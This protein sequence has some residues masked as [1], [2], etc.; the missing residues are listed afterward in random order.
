MTVTELAI[1]ARIG[2]RD[3]SRADVLAWED[4]PSHLL[5][6]GREGTWEEKIGGSTPPILTEAGWLTLYHG[7]ADGGAAARPGESAAGAGPDAGT[8]PRT[9]IFL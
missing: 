3:Y 9:R 4:K 6:A 5:I 2:G 7:V 1:T 8:D